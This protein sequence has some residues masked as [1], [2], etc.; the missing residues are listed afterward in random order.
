VA[1]DSILLLNAWC[2]MH[3]ETDKD[4]NRIKFTS[5]VRLQF[6]ELPA[7]PVYDAWVCSLP[8]DECSWFILVTKGS[9]RAGDFMSQS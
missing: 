8:P 4:G 3:E 7:D 9:T 1:A 6:V 5:K 2:P